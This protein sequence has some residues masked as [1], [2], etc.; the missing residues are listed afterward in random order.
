MAKSLK[1]PEDQFKKR[2]WREIAPQ[3]AIATTRL[4]AG[5]EDPPVRRGPPN[6][7]IGFW[8]V[9]TRVE[10]WYAK[11]AKGHTVEVAGASH[12][13][14]SIPAAKFATEP[15]KVLNQF[16]FVLIAVAGWMNQRQ[17]QI[18]D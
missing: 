9:S 13:A 18:I 5:V 3:A 8:G 16:W 6:G 14:S 7:P 12:S 2:A 17:L 11:R 15:P 10:R 4:P 1:V